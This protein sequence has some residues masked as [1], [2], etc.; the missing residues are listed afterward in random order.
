MAGKNSVDIQCKVS[1]I[2]QQFRCSIKKTILSLESM[3]K[4]YS[5][6]EQNRMIFRHTVLQFPTLYERVLFCQLL[7]WNSY[8]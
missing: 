7:R 6:K 5:L 1:E 8:C 3:P 2:D 4:R